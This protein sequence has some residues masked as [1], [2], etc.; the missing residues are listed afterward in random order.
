VTEPVDLVCLPEGITVIGTGKS[1]ADVSEAAPG[2]TTER[3][4]RL[5]RKLNA[6]IVAGIYEREGR[7]VYN[8]AV[9]LDRQGRL[10]GKYR[11]THL[12][13]EE[14]EAG[15]TPGDAYPVFT[16]DFGRIGLIICYDLQFPEPSRAMAAQGAEILVLPIWGGFDTLARARALE[17]SVY[18]IS[19]TYDMRSYIL[20]PTGAI[21][22]EATREQ[23]LARAEIDLETQFFLPWNGNMKTRTWKEWRPDLPTTPPLK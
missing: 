1:Y 17:N 18:L 15:I 6:Y 10:A 4:G 11:K 13:R 16:T 5:A 20:D 14:W 22:A 12:P 23:P 7:V 19:S 3:L 21:L 9:L 2:P 8:T